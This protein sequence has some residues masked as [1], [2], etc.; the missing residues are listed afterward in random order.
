MS[1]TRLQVGILILKIIERVIEHYNY[2]VISIKIET[3][4]KHI[5]NKL[6]TDNIKKLQLLINERRNIPVL[7]INFIHR[8]KAK[9]LS[10][11]YRNI[12]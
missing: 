6:T 3:I 5:E 12:S 10:D 1:M 11:L 4:Q 9:E 8:K 7:E 2:H